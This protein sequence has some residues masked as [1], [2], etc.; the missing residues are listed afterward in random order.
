MEILLEETYQTK[1]RNEAF[2]MW[3]LAQASVIC[4]TLVELIKY[5]CLQWSWGGAWEDDKSGLVLFCHV[6]G[7][8][9]LH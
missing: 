1:K 7:S 5:C 3:K 4:F 6:G 2:Y 9:I 8:L